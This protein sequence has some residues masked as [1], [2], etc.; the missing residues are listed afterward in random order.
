MTARVLASEAKTAGVLGRGSKVDHERR[1][2][3]SRVRVK[4]AR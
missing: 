3:G 2:L 4:S 1:Y